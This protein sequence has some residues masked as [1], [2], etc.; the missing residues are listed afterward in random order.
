MRW[1]Q[2][3]SGCGNLSRLQ[4]Q[5]DAGGSFGRQPK[6]AAGSELLWSGNSHVYV[7]LLQFPVAI[8]ATTETI[9]GVPRTRANVA[10]TEAVRA[11]GLRPYVLP[12]LEGADANAMLDGMAGLVLTGGEDVD[13]RHYGAMA[14][15]KL[16]EVHADRDAFELA[17]VRAARARGLPTLAICRG[18]QVLNVALGGTL[19][20]DLPDERPGTLPHDG[21]WERDARVHAAHVIPASRLAAMVNGTAL[22]VNSLHHQAIDRVADGIIVVAQS[23]DGVIEGVESSAPAWWMVGVQWHPEE[24]VRTPDEWDRAIFAGFARAVRERALTPPVATAPRS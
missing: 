3:R 10:Y 2:R 24:L 16:G 8:T 12:V 9:R 6:P 19:V 21:A 11:A 14:H 13:P 18:V 22:L 20:Q 5:P 4:P 7:V 15:P 1:C 17:L 23:P